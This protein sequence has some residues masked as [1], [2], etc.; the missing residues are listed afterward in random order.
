MRKNK[1]ER[2]S[3]YSTGS[4]S[5][6]LILCCKATNHVFENT[7]GHFLVSPS[8][9]TGVGRRWKKVAGGTKREIPK[10]MVSSFFRIFRPHGIRKTFPFWLVHSLK[11][12]NDA[13]I[14][15]HLLDVSLLSCCRETATTRHQKIDWPF[16]CHKM[17]SF[18]LVQRILKACKVWLLLLIAHPLVNL[19]DITTHL[20]HFYLF[21]VDSLGGSLVHPLV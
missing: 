8:P 4:Q 13:I 1:P 12:H 14:I 6:H 9:F 5:K 17:V 2:Q 10:K 18:Q 11:N 7:N 21:L 15:Y 20:S 16:Y 3:N 19:S